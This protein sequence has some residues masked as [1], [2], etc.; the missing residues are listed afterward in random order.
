MSVKK[1]NCVIVYQIYFIEGE[2]RGMTAKKHCHLRL[3]HDFCHIYD[4]SHIWLE[5]L[6]LIQNCD[7]NKL[8]FQI[9]SLLNVIL[10]VFWSTKP[11]QFQLNTG[12]AE[13]CLRVC[14]KSVRMVTFFKQYISAKF[15]WTS[16]GQRG[17]KI[18]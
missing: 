1:N 15:V 13:L 3:C 9:N 12:Q 17:L 10:F 14:L 5:I 2:F 16:V 11:G 8:S 6:S 4:I 18:I 7:A